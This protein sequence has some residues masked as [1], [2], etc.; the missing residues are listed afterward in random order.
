MS[1]RRNRGRFRSLVLRMR[2]TRPMASLA[3]DAQNESS[4]LIVVFGFLRWNRLEVGSVTL[5]AA[6]KNRPVEVRDAL[7][8]SRA[9]DPSFQIRPVRHRQLKKLAAFPIQIGLA[10]V[11]GTG[12]DIDPLRSG[13]LFRR[14]PEHGG[15]VKSAFFRVHAEMKIRIAGLQNIL[16]ARKTAQDGILGGKLRG[17]M[18]R[19]VRVR[20]ADLLVAFLAS[21]VPQEVAASGWCLFGDGCVGLDRENGFSVLTCS[22]SSA[23]GDERSSTH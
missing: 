14:L 23:S 22:R 18:V 12:D 9:G 6:R 19:G 2:S 5:Q 17:Q 15:F 4:F 13:L 7:A 8:V 1:G 10:L 16:A 21:G 20:A 11:S 3:R